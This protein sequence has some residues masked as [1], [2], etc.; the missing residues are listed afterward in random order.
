M[1]TK[2]YEELSKL[3]NSNNIKLNESMKK[4]SSFKVGGPADIMILPENELE[5]KSI[6][7]T[8]N[9]NNIPFCIIGN[10]SNLL[11]RD[12]GIRGVVIKISSHF[13]KISISGNIITAQA[14]A[15]LPVIAQQALKNNLQGFE[16][17]A[18]IPGTLGGAI[19]MNAGAHGGEMKD[20]VTSVR[21]MDYEGAIKTLSNDEMKF[22]YRNSVLSKDNYIVLSVEMQLQPGDHQKIKATMDEYK[23]RRVDTQPLNM[24]SAGSTFKRVDGVSVGKI[25]EDLGLKGLSLN[26]AQVSK[27]HGGFIVNSEE[28]T[29][30]KDI[31]NLIEVVKSIVKS[32]CNIEL[33]EEVRVIGE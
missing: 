31:L 9:A 20:I 5:L 24:P 21:V 33:E 26:G 19:R 8:L 1:H 2:I 27:K 25:L 3:T 30:A 22:E 15:L 10:G 29:T 12:N 6:L 16:A 7:K 23:N 28:D 18:G 11:V 13:N 14:G 4:H 17:V 32:T